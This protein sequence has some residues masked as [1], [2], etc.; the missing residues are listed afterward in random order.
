M[1]RAITDEELLRC[2]DGIRRAMR[3]FAAPRLRNVTFLNLESFLYDRAAERGELMPLL[4]MVEPYIPLAVS[5]ANIEQLLDAAR[6]GDE[7]AIVDMENVL[8]SRA[9]VKFLNA[10]YAAQTPEAWA[11]IVT[12]CQTIRGYKAETSRG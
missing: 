5:C 6:T 9:K 4:R 11:A 3:R 7:Q 12:V 8:V 1:N 10:V 2:L